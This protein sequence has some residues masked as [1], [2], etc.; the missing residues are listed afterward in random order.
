MGLLDHFFTQMNNDHSNRDM[1]DTCVQ[2]LGKSVPISREV[3]HYTT[4]TT[5][6]AVADGTGILIVATTD[7]GLPISGCFSFPLRLRSKL[8]V[9]FPKG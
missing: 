1:C 5:P 9:F 7:T 3:E 4:S 2:G 6:A 8:H